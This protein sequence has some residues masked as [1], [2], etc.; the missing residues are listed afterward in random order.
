MCDDDLSRYH[1][2]IPSHLIS[3]NLA[4]PFLVVQDSE[5]SIASELSKAKDWSFEGYE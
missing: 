3:K 2:D 1:H 5:F 4:G